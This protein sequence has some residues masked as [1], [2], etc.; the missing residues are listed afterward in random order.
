MVFG[1]LEKGGVTAEMHS[2]V[3]ARFSNVT[4]AVSFNARAEAFPPPMDVFVSHWLLERAGAFDGCYS[5]VRS[6]AK[7]RWLY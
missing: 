2:S 7:R 6:L 4:T 3:G 5:V 1:K